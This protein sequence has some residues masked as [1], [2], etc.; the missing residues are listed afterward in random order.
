MATGRVR[1]AGAGLLGLLKLPPKHLTPHHQITMA[2][3]KRRSHLR[4]WRAMFYEI[5]L[6]YMYPYGITAWLDF[7]GGGVQGVGGE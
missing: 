7:G 2:M 4:T 5:F 3:A 6:G 1:K